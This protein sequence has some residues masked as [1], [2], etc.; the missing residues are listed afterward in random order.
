MSSREYSHK[1]RQPS[2]LRVL[3]PVSRQI[4]ESVAQIIGPHSAAQQALDDAAKH[5]GPVNF[6]QR[7]NTIIVEK[8]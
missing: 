5:D 4:L 3:S 2:G 1:A 8:L 6:Y 7:G